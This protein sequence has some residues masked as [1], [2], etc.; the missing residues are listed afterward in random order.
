MQQSCLAQIISHYRIC[1]EGTPQSS[2]EMPHI[3]AEGAAEMPARVGSV[4]QP[5]CVWENATRQ[6]TWIQKFNWGLSQ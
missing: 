6:Q 2:G 5:E 1:W 4:I 3:L